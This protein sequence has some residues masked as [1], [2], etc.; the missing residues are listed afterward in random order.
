MGYV[1]A[2]G[3]GFD[4]IEKILA[5]LPAGEEVVDPGEQAISTEFPGV[6]RSL[7]TDGLGHMQSVLARLARQDI[8]SA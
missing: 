6:A 8:R 5:A 4:G 2:I 3:C 1:I 7:K